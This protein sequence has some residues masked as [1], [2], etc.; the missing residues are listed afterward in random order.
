MITQSLKH[1]VQMLSMF[2]FI[3]GI[4]QNI[5]NENDHELVQLWHEYGVHQV[6]EISQGIGQP[7]RH[8][9]K[10]I[11][12]ISG[13]ESRLRNITGTDLDLMLARA[14]V[15]LGEHFGSHQLSK[16]NINAGQRVF[17][18]DGYRPLNA[19]TI[20]N[21]YP[22]PRIDVLFDQLVGSKVFSKIDLRSSYH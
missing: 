15:Y 21:K 2:V 20:K 7:K 12:S 1:D 19:V 18:L 6:H 5:I 11:E 13:R 8:H 17:V 9:Q 22:L 4:D 14:K 16:Q 3:L 10:L